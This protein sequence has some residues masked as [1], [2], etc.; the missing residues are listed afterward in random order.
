MNELR[1]FVSPE[2]VFG[3]KALDMAGQ[4]AY[5]LGAQKVFVV[6]DRGVGLAGWT[7][8]VCKSLEKFNLAYELFDEV[9]QNPRAEE[10]MKGGKHTGLRSVISSLPSGEA[11]PLIARKA[12]A[13]LFP[14]A[15]TFSNLPASTMLTYPDL[16]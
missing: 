15:R 16:P 12:S 6:S 2:F 7:R 13:S 14:T 11:V 10:V 5:N 1:K 4:Y 9:S 3:V 8:N